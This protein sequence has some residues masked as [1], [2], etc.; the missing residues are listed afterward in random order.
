MHSRERVQYAAYGPRREAVVAFDMPSCAEKRGLSACRARIFE[1]KR[2]KILICVVC[3]IESLNHRT[4]ESRGIRG[5]WVSAFRP[6]FHSTPSHISRPAPTLLFVSFN[7]PG[8]R[9]RMRSNSSHVFR[10]EM[11][12]QM[13]SRGLVGIKGIGN[14]PTPA[15]GLVKCATASV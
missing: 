5:C 3:F 12:M 10:T 15:K 8:T 1:E 13:R 9:T 2:K 14:Q 4:V 6:F 11:R 7:A